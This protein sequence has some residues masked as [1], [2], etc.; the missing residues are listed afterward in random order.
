MPLTEPADGIPE[1]TVTDAG[2]DA[3]IRA[4][5][6]G[7]GAVAVDAERA[8]GFRYGQHAYL[9]QLRRDGA[10]TILIDPRSLPDLTGVSTALTGVEWVFHA[11]SQDLPSLAE[12]GL[13]PDAIFDTELAGRLLNKER[14]GLGPLVAAELHLA[15][16]KEHSAADW[17]KRP[18]P[19]DWLRYAALDVEFL[20]ELRDRLAAELEQAGKLAWAEQEFEAVRTAPDPEPRVDPWRR[21]SGTH[22][23][24]DRRSLAVVREL[25]LARDEAARAADISPGRIL[26]DAAIIAAA[27]AGAADLADLREFRARGASRRLRRWQ[28]ARDR[29]LALPESELPPRRVDDPDHLPN[30]RGWRERHPEAALRLEA[31]KRIVRSTAARLELPQENLLT[32]DYQRRLAWAPPEEP[33]IDAVRAALADLGARPWQLEQVTEGLLDAVRAPEHVLETVPAPEP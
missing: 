33:S 6:S 15:L 2:L 5:G 18:L 3:A 9:V 27:T 11:A 8:S 7:R 28:E 20:V 31:V 26:P 32:P 25:W 22:R 30:P 17:S 13:H 21:T 1:V 12:V 23:L 10:G 16:A 14:V 4:L 29:A 19:E 24:R